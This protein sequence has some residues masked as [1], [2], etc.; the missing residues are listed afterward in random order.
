MET[1]E[2]QPIVADSPLRVS[3]IVPNFNG[4]AFLSRTLASIEA[5]V[6]PDIEVIV[7]D[8]GS[9]DGSLDI[10]ADWADRVNLR[11]VS[12]PDSGQAEAINKGF[13]MATGEVMGWIN[14]DDLLAPRAV[15]WAAERF[16]A[17]P[18]LGFVWGFCLV[19]DTD[20]QPVTIQNPYVRSDLADLRRHRNYVSQPGSFY[21]RTVV[22]EFGPLNENLHYLFDYD[23]FLR[24]AG[25]VEA[26]F[27]PEVMAWFR[28][29]STS[30]SGSQVGAFLKE[31]PQVYRANGG[32]WL[33]PF[34][35][36]YLRN[37]FWTRP[38]GRLKEPLRGVA[39]RVLGV[40]PGGRIRS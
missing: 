11:W 34:W 19:I 40:P 36:D 21:R 39:R 13:R 6:Y 16:A 7:I 9:S 3:V 28:I 23:F 30:K 10:I 20:E 18:D 32:R 1:M 5:Q 8:G 25:R 4:A 15:Q 12:E 35:F 31:E 33:S 26:A 2:S 14:S 24:V 37:R 27:I 22:Q 38:F 29:H 17:K